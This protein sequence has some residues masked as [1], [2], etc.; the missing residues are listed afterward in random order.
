MAIVQLN[1]ALT[2]LHGRV[3]DRI[4]KTYGRKVVET[5]V[6]CFD[7]YIPTTAQHAR[8]ALLREATAFAQR[9]YA[10]PAA[11]AAYVAAA[12]RLHRQPFRLAIADYLLAPTPAAIDLSRFPPGE[13][14][15]IRR[16]LAP[17]RF[18]PPR[19]RCTNSHAR[20]VHARSRGRTPLARIIRLC[21]DV[22]RREASAPPD[23]RTDFSQA[24]RTGHRCAPRRG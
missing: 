8:R 2:A 9:I 1:S 18:A 22:H 19:P 14:E 24:G 15:T 21:F 13:A 7:G 11:K 16:L 5:R 10:D 6:P 4:Y 17:P 23:D 3:G 20:R 12:R